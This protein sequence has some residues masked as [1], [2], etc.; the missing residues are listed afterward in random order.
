MIKAIP[1]VPDAAPSS[2]SSSMMKLPQPVVKME[3]IK[4]STIIKEPQPQ[5][6]ATTTHSPKPPL[7]MK[8]ALECPLFLRSKYYVATM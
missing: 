5:A 1:I 6:K 4:T 2:S 7:K 8:E 3:T